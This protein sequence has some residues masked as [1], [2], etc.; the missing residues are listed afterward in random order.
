LLLGV[1][2][3]QEVNMA[4]GREGLEKL[5]TSERKGVKEK[6]GFHPE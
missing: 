1:Q 6:F 5:L 2:Q 4:N 3:Q